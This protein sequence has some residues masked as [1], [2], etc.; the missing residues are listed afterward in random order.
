MSS[1]TYVLAISGGV[2]SVV[3]LDKLIK[4]QPSNIKYIVAHFDHGIRDNSYLDAEFVKTLAEKYKLE[5]EK[6]LGSLESDVSEESARNARYEFLREVKSK[7]QAEAIITA[8]HQ[9]DVLETVV[10]NI[11]RNAS[12]RGLI[13]YS[14]PDVLRPFINKTK[15]EILKYAKNNKLKWQEDITNENTDYTRNYIRKN[16]IPKLENNR[17]DFLSIRERVAENYQEIDYLSKKLLVQI[18]QDGQIIRSKFV[19][20]PFVVQKQLFATYFKINNIEY[21]KNMVVNAAIA[22]K[23]LLPN[24]HVELSKNVKIYSNKQ[25]VLIKYHP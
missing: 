24:K 25:S 16:I 1:K 9:D 6:G 14:Q 2:D 13:G 12:P 10:L 23:V 22:V 5:Y 19:N 7:Y 8:H 4:K 17:Q 11:L 20:L 18:M 21:T 15:A 3:L